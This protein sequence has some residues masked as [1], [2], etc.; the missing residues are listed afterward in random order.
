MA[1]WH[2]ITIPINISLDI[3]N[4]FSDIQ[5]GWGSLPVNVIV[6]STKWKTSIF[7]DKQTGGYLM[8]IKAGVRKKEEIEDDDIVNVTIEILSTL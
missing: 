8:P 6:G 3:K 7:P 5:R 2:F 1:G 4:K